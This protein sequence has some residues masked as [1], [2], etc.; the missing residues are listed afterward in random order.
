[1][2]NYSGQIAVVPLGTAG[3]YTDNP[4]SIIPA[5]NLIRGDNLTYYNG[6]LEKAYGSRI[7]NTSP[8]AAGVVQFHEMYTDTQSQNQRVFAL[9]QDGT[10]W[11]FTNNFT[12]TLVTMT[13]ATQ[14][15][16]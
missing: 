7:W 6:V 10:V 5:T 14:T 16:L 2:M 12:Q 3:I 13:D 15:H 1:M 9:L 8:L 4:Q 11:R